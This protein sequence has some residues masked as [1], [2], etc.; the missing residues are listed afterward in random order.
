MS[1]DW[2]VSNV[3]N[4]KNR[5]W[6]LTNNPKKKDEKRLANDTNSL[7]WGAMY[8]GLSG[9]RSNNVEEWVW[10]IEFCRRL[11]IGW[12]QDFDADSKVVYW[13]P[14]AKSVREHI[15]LRTNVTN[16]TRTKWRNRMLKV[17]EREVTENAEQELRDDC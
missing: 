15:G 8:L 12:M 2:S 10:R 11:N 17:L 7:I 13:Y 9:I 5:C 4:W 16:E 1:L 6:V 14:N 3:E